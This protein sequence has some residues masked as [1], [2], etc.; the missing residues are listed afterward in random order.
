MISTFEQAIELFRLA[1]RTRMAVRFR[2]DGFPELI[3][4]WQWWEGVRGWHIY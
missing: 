1:K 4:L 2:D 3:V